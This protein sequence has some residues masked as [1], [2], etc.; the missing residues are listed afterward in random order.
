MFR[1]TQHSQYGWLNHSTPVLLKKRTSFKLKI[2]AYR[3]RRTRKFSKGVGGAG[4]RH[5][6]AQIAPE[7]AW[8]DLFL[9]GAKHLFGCVKWKKKEMVNGQA[10]FCYI[11]WHP[12]WW[13]YGQ[14]N[15][16]G[17]WHFRLKTEKSHWSQAQKTHND[18]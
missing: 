17:D 10:L 14:K 7:I 4:G 1:S 9:A 6:N 3:H 18:E 13:R 8:I 5:L 11:S 2:K 12:V 16:E 15:V